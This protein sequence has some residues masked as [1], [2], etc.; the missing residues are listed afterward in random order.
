MTEPTRSGSELVRRL[1]VPLAAMTIAFGAGWSVGAGRQPATDWQVAT[2]SVDGGT[3]R[4]TVGKSTFEIGS[5]V[6]VWIGT[7]GA[8]HTAGHPACLDST[9]GGSGS[10]KVVVGTI[11]ADGKKVDA[12]VAFDC[13]A[14]S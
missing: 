14:S 10:H 8:T 6:P 7:D 11:T 9:D 12:V 5:S 2:V 3:A 4:A 13:R 1:V